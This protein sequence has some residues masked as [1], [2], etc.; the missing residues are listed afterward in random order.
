[1]F[2]VLSGISLRQCWVPTTVLGAT[3]IV[4]DIIIVA[5]MHANS[6]V[7]SGIGGLLVIFIGAGSL[8]LPPRY[9]ALLAAFATL[10]ILGQQI[11]SQVFEL[12]VP[13]NYPAAGIL[14]GI[15]FAI[16]LAAH[17]LAHEIRNP[18]GAMSHAAQLLGESAALT[19]DDV[20]LEVDVDDAVDN[21]SSLLEPMIMAI[22]R[23][24]VGGLV[25][26]MY[27]PIFK[28]GAVV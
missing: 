13:T 17:P 9:P 23:V 28:L 12:A 20:Q 25:V 3:Q 4:V 22:L 1:M 16:A 26:A 7:S 19:E 14:S 5:L 24:L 15:I 2:A 27:L 18:V 21:L 11:L 10:A 6:G 8:V